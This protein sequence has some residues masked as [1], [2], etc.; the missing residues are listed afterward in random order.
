MSS[1]PEYKTLITL[2][3]LLRDA[4]QHDLV[5]LSDGLV[6][7]VLITPNHGSELRNTSHSESDRAARLVELI[8]SK[9]QQ[10]AKHYDTFVQVLENQD[11]EYYS[12]ILSRLREVYR[13]HKDD[14]LQQ[15]ASLSRTQTSVH[16]RP[17]AEKRS[18]VRQRQTGVYI[19]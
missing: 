16:S 14:C 6:S 1:T 4:I 13:Q 12:D 8:Q 15:P 2:T 19:M 9:V 11:R 10:N 5:A 17:S 18:T 7:E 3:S